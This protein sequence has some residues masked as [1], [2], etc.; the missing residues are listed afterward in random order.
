MRAG[1][2]AARHLI[3]ALVM[4][5]APHAAHAQS[6]QAWSLQG[7][8][9]L[10]S[11]EINGRLVT[12]LGGE[13]QLRYTPAS[14]FS[15]GAGFQLTQHTSG[16]EQLILTAVFVEPRYTLDIGGDKLAP[17]LAG[18]LAVVH[19]SS[20]LIGAPGVSSNGT[21][22]GGGAGIL[23]RATRTV[24]VD[25]G[26]AVVY[27]SLGDATASNGARVQFKAFAGYIAKLGVNVGFG[28]R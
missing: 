7:S 5:G 25:L 10:A 1:A 15:L 23:F 6:A 9:L 24:N 13:G 2:Q 8:V 4:V 28:G 17:Y 19:E 22:I 21:A 12:G 11:Q 3:V 20:D 18:R 26:V 27:Q 16:T 14:L